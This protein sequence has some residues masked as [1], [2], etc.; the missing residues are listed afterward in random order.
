VQPRVFVTRRVRAADDAREALDRFVAGDGGVHGGLAL[1]R[2][3]DLPAAAFAAAP[4]PDVSLARV[5]SGEPPPRF[6]HDG[7][8]ALEIEAELHAPGLLVVNDTMLDGWTAAVDGAA[9]P[10]VEVNGL[11]RGVWLE[12]G[13]HRVTMRY[14]PPGLVAG[15]AISAA[16]LLALALVAWLAR[17]RVLRGVGVHVAEPAFARAGR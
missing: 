11:V 6:V 10:I 12:A 13:S 17:R 15:A 8:H 14:V 2:R 1:V 7:R 16:A 3:G 4:T 9:A 5:A